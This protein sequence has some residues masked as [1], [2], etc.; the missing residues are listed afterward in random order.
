MR[1]YI[2]GTNRDWSRNITPQSDW[3]LSFAE[4]NSA[5]DCCRQ[6][7]SERNNG[8]SVRSHFLDSGAFT[9]KTKAAEYAKKH[10]TDKWAW[11]RSKEMRQYLDDYAQFVKEHKVGIDLYANVDVMGNP[12]LTLR[13]QRY[14]ERKH[15]LVPVPVVHF[16]TEL[17][18]LDKYVSMGYEIIGLGGLV[19]SMSKPEC[20]AWLDSCFD[21]VCNNSQR[22]PCVKLHGFGVTRYKF[23]IRYPWWSVDSSTWTKICAFGGILVPH[24]RRGAFVFSEAPYVMKMSYESPSRDNRGSHYLTLSTLE[25]SIVDDWLKEI[26][27][28][29][30]KANADGEEIEPGVMTNYVDRA[31]ANV[32]FFERMCKSLPEWPWPFSSGKPTGFDLK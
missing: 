11:Y 31:K 32:I 20:R 23:M 16:G 27:V 5:S 26:E 22:L 13:N 19:G 21:L 6:I 14:L 28:P 24:K 25:R 8:M 18:W 15:G 12:D 3:M 4:P 9:L 2:S 29:L 17:K 7:E 30:G 10:G 1:V